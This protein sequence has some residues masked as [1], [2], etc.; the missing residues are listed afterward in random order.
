MNFSESCGL[1]V[2]ERFFFRFRVDAFG[3]IE[4]IY[5]VWDLVVGVF[6]EVFFRSGCGLLR[7]VE[8]AFFLRD[9]IDV[10]VLK[11]GR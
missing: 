5:W 4:L 11:V 9:I 3:F 2:R 1:I 7:V 8:F 6:L 10:I